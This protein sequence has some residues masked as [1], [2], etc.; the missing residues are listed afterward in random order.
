MRP[1]QSRLRLIVV[2]IILIILVILLILIILIILA[3]LVTAHD[4]CCAVAAST[5]ELLC[6]RSFPF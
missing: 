6:K 1:K 2:L 4:S 5:T 3:I